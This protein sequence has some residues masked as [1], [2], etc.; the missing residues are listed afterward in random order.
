MGQ[1][2][3]PRGMKKISHETKKTIPWD[4]AA[5]TV[6]WMPEL[7]W[8]ITSISSSFSF[9]FLLLLLYKEYIRK[10]NVLFVLTKVLNNNNLFFDFLLFP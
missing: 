4:E 2:V 6:R 7:V 5:H 8:I 9:S 3:L 1:K 10:K